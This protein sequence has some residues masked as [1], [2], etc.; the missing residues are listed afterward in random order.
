LKKS[1]WKDRV[2]VPEN[3]EKQREIAAIAKK[4][5]EEIPK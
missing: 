5:I 4:P 3:I 2:A 1:T